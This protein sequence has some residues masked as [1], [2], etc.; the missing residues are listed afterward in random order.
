MLLIYYTINRGELMEVEKITDPKAFNPASPWAQFVETFVHNLTHPLSILLLQI[1]VIIFIARIFGAICRKIG[2]PTVIGEIVAGIIL[3]PS[4]LGLYFPE[5]SSFIFPVQS[6]GNLQFLSQVGL[7][8]FMFIVGMEVDMKVLKNKGHE[9]VVISHVSIIFPFLLGVVLAYF[10]YREFAPANIPFHSFALFIGI[11][12]SITA[13]PVLAR[14][15]QERGLSKTK[16]GALVITCAAAD[17]I[18]AWC[19]LAAVIAIVKAGTFTSAIY[20][21]IIAVIYVIVMIRVIQPFLKK[22]GDVYSN[23]EGLSKPIVAI[24]FTTLILSAYTTEIIGIHALFGAFMAGL[25]MPPN[26][27]FRS[28]FI[29]KV[30]DVAIVLLLPLFFVF[31]GLRTQINLIDDAS[32]WG[33]CG[34]II[35]VAVAGKFMGSTIAARFVGQSWHESLSVGAL[36]NT[37]GL[38]ELVVLNIGYDLGI[39]VPEV[40]A[41]LVIMALVT[42]FMTGPALNI[43]NKVF[44]HPAGVL[45][46]NGLDHAGKYKILISFGDPGRGRKMLML[47]ASLIKKATSNA[48]ITALHLS[49]S[50]ELNQYNISEYEADSFEPIKEEAE[51]LNLPLLTMFKPSQDI[52]RDIVQVAHIGKFDLMIIGTG[53]SV[54][55]GSLLGKVLG[56]TTRLI[57]PEH[58]YGTL[59][60]REKL[61][62]NIF[63][64]RTRTIMRSSRIPLGIFIDKGLQK[65]KEIIIPLLSLEDGVLLTYAQKLIT[66]SDVRVSV[67]DLQEVTKKNSGLKES[68]RLIEQIAP[69]HIALHTNAT[70]ED[71]LALTPDLLLITLKSWTMAFEDQSLWLP[72][73]PSVL[74]LK[75]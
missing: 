24:F 19:I 49:P 30:E 67:Y 12:M 3:G 65:V 73:T 48:S 74:V 21:I 2:Q 28:L 31:T 70:M 43:I 50:N 36:M 71:A 33:V 4:F 37:R 16:L 34:L 20:T 32:M 63:D 56:L 64:E 10:L 53:Q 18:T 42:T 57:N 66:N 35:L 75:T 44:A 46:Q 62:N 17:D 39:L 51:K 52:E 58:L 7:I 8:L 41:M 1:L 45:N 27:S 11:T 68:I 14:I 13:F 60:G 5:F 22:I 9:A 69:N 40:F 15:V 26:M 38:V 6:L 72:Q 54:F 61:F 23:R 59:R 55:E 25:M 47:A 29:E